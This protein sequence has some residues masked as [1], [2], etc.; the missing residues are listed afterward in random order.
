M[1]NRNENSQKVS[2][3]ATIRQRV[4]QGSI[5]GPLLFI[6]YING[7]PKIINTTSS[8]IIFADDTNILFTHSNLPD[9][10]R[11]IDIVFKTLN[12]WLR[13]NQLFLNFKKTL[14]SFYT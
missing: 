11:N 8:P 12:K 10:H 2:N 5:L 1:H 14:C 13:A 7:L 9:L 6:L 3:W 4:P